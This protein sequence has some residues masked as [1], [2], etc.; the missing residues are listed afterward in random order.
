MKSKIKIILCVTALAV[1]LSG[2]ASE[3]IGNDISKLI[4]PQEF[5]SVLP[6]NAPSSELPADGSAKNGYESLQ[7]D[8]IYTINM[9]WELSGGY[10]ISEEFKFAINPLWRDRFDLESELMG[11]EETGFRSFNFYYVEEDTDIRVRLLR[12]DAMP[13]EMVDDVG[14]LGG[15]ELGRSG[16]EEWVYLKMPIRIDGDSLPEEF[17]S[18][19]EIYAIMI[20]IN[21]DAFDFSVTT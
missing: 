14:T 21:S 3:Y 7:P 16:N 6:D 4:N 15:E 20:D 9:Q 10:F 13:A 17:H 11:T 18:G 12:I 8:T 1:M 2:C 5:G 19:A